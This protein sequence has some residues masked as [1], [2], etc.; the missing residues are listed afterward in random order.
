MKCSVTAYIMHRVMQCVPRWLLLPLVAITMAPVGLCIRPQYEDVS[1][2]VD[3]G[4][5]FAELK[6]NPSLLSVRGDYYHEV[7]EGRKDPPAFELRGLV[8]YFRGNVSAA[9]A[10][11]L[12]CAEIDNF[13]HYSRFCLL[14]C[15]L[16]LRKRDRDVP[17]YFSNAFR[18]AWHLAQ[19]APE[20]MAVWDTFVQLSIQWIQ[21]DAKNKT[22]LSDESTS[23][24][25]RVMNDGLPL[26]LAFFPQKAELLYVQAIRY[27]QG[28]DHFCAREYFRWSLQHAASLAS[29][30]FNS[31]DHIKTCERNIEW[32][33][34]K[35]SKNEAHKNVNDCFNLLQAPAEYLT[36]VGLNAS[37]PV[38]LPYLTQMYR[39]T[40]T[41]NSLYMPV[42]SWASFV[43]IHLDILQKNYLSLGTYEGH[44]SSD[45]VLRGSLFHHYQQIG[46]SMFPNHAGLVLLQGIQYLDR[47]NAFCAVHLLQKAEALWE[48]RQRKE[49]AKFSR[50]MVA[51]AQTR[52]LSE[53]KLWDTRHPEKECIPAS[54]YESLEVSP[55]LRAAFQAAT[56]SIEIKQAI[57]ECNRAMEP[58]LS[59]L[60]AI[61]YS[62]ISLVMQSISKT[63]WELSY[64]RSF[65]SGCRVLQIGCSVP[66][67]VR[68]GWVVADSVETYVPHVIAEAHNLT[69][70]ANSSMSVLYASHIFEHIRRPLVNTTLSEW[71]RVLA[72]G[73][74]L[75]LAVP[76]IEAIAKMILD[77]DLRY[78]DK[79]I[80][81]DVIY[82]GGENEWNMHYAGY[83][84]ESLCNLLQ[85]NG[86]CNA[87][88][89]TS[90]GIFG[91]GSEFDMDGRFSLSLNIVATSC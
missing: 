57:F 35:L 52:L 79:V 46:I 91:D 21:A 27:A 44:F 73:G 64:T 10:N 74:M 37:D 2:D 30:L 76:D 45:S 62:N 85:E 43:W 51:I 49:F 26:G 83:F 14:N 38:Q 17:N 23:E 84:D 71:R 89:V 13:G 24:I 72:P 53:G 48:K 54:N 20:V 66:Y 88:R 28:S 31:S 65:F 56:N 86:F 22:L 41:L 3:L 16:L 70:I 18:D 80:L 55:E 90:F 60:Q 7:T 67:C 40:R 15:A 47:D 4:V 58:T 5:L 1:A 39:L 77:P 78:K 25:E 32:C 8:Q 36:L 69:A 63:Y 9:Y 33:T 61:E 75:L 34:S 42:D 81:M 12:S 19:N 82:G 59:G 50:N 29:E 11:Y 6:E 68:P 87:R